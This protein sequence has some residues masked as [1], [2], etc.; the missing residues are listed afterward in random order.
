VIARPI[1]HCPC[2]EADLRTANTW[3]AT[4]SAACLLRR[5]NQKTA[6]DYVAI[7]VELAR[8]MQELLGEG[9]RERLLA[10]RLIRAAGRRDSQTGWRKLQ[11]PHSNAVEARTPEH[12]HQ[13]RLMECNR[14]D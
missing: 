14:W 5:V 2:C 4:A 7:S 9:K 12:P 1:T 11:A 8:W 6:E 3:A 13:L 10:R